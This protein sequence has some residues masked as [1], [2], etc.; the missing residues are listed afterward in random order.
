MDRLIKVG[1]KH[2]GGEPSL[3][4]HYE[5][6]KEER[7]VLLAARRRTRIDLGRAATAARAEALCH[8]LK[9]IS[10]AAARL[11][12]ARWRQERARAVEELE[13]AIK[14]GH[15]TEAAALARRLAG[16]GRGARR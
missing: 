4:E 12:R 13:V 2:F 5:E 14:C 16:T 10:R 8:R 15:D 7:V 9:V 3:G 11:R 1:E 6:L